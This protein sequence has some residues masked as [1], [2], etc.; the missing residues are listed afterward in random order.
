MHSCSRFARTCFSSL[1]SIVFSLRHASLRSYYT[2]CVAQRFPHVFSLLCCARNVIIVF[3]SSLLC[4]CTVVH[5]SRH[6]P[7]V[8]IL[9]LGLS[10]RSPPSSSTSTDPVSGHSDGSLSTHSSSTALDGL[11]PSHNSISEGAP[12]SPPENAKFF[13]ENMI[14]KLKIIAGV[15]IIGGIIAGI[16][17]SHIKHQHRDCQDS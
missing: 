12:P 14:K 3:C 5:L 4:V 15:T 7:R 10:F 8:F 9:D 2:R 1:S 17:G 6:L 13:N 11:A 16:A